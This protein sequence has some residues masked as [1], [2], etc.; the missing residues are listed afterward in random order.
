M[1]EG[2]AVRREVVVL[3]QGSSNL[4]RHPILSG[5]G[6]L[7]VALAFQAKESGSIPLPRSNNFGE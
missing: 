2:N 7:V 4:P 6:I 3:L 1:A 5:I